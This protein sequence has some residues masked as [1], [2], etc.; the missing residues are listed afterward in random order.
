M[1]V[2]DLH[3]S[4]GVYAYTVFSVFNKTGLISVQ[5]PEGLFYRSLVTDL[6]LDIEALT[7]TSPLDVTLST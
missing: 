2:L 3:W 5:M 4:L 1:Q 7:A 6:L